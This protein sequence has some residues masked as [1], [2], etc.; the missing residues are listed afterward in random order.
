M[1]RFT[2]F[3][4]LLLLV[5]LTIAVASPPSVSA[6]WE[7]KAGN[8]ISNTIFGWTNCPKAW[9]DEIGKF[10]DGFWRGLAGTLITG[11][12][13][14]GANVAA[15]YVAVPVDAATIPWGKN[16]LPPAAHE[17]KPPLRFDR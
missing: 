15:T 17:A 3:V 12:L 7:E 13:L 16:V 10:K 9:A 5:V 14:C 6:D 4:G 1:K 11:P 2:V 8:T